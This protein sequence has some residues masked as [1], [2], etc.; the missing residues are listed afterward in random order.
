[1][2]KKISI[3]LLS[4]FFVIFLLFIIFDC[5]NI[6]SA[7][8]INYIH[9][10]WFGTLATL[11][12]DLS[13][14]YFTISIAKSQKKIESDKIASEKFFKISFIQ[15]F[16]RID[17]VPVPNLKLKNRKIIFLIKLQLIAI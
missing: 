15:E 6:P 7:L 14:L 9:F 17:L 12:V 5:N 16:Q 8:G 11:L 2:K 3:M 4:F 13:T 1:M 10:D